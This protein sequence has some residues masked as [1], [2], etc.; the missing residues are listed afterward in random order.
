MIVPGRDQRGAVGGVRQPPHLLVV[1]GEPG[2]R[3]GLLDEMPGANRAAP[4]RIRSGIRLRARRPGIPHAPTCRGTRASFRPED[5]SQRVA[6]RPIPPPASIF[7]SGEK[8]K[9]SSPPETLS[10]GTRRGFVL[11]VPDQD[12]GLDGR[13]RRPASRFPSGENTEEGPTGRQRDRTQLARRRPH[14]R[15]D[16]CPIG[17]GEDVAVGRGGDLGDPGERPGKRLPRP[18]GRRVPERHVAGGRTR[19]QPSAVRG[20][21]HPRTGDRCRPGHGVFRAA[22]E[23]PEDQPVLRRSPSRSCSRSTCGRCLGG[24]RQVDDV[25][26]DPRD[27]GERAGG[28]RVPERDLARRP[29]GYPSTR[30]PGPG[31]RA[32]TTGRSQVPRAQR[33]GRVPA[34][35]RGP[36][37]PGRRPH[38]P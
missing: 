22:G 15:T 13:P 35:W 5:V 25:S 17:H 2:A 8:A 36:R 3:F 4:R 34:P 6:G 20:I 24:K 29:A 18:A 9:R 23:I 28:T 12:D 14:P 30:R 19:R 21:G 32:R 27:A 7:P 1:A 38:A 33:P 11:S 16:P 10:S 26:R 37:R 31:R